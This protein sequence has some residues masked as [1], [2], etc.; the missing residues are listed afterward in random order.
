[1]DAKWFYIV[2]GMSVEG[3]LWCAALHWG[4]LLTLFIVSGAMCWYSAEHRIEKE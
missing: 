4:G 1:M 2:C 3:A